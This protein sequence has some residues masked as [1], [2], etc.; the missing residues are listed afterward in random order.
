MLPVHTNQIK[1]LLVVVGFF[2]FTLQGFSQ[3]NEGTDFWFGFMEHRDVNDNT[4]VAMITS[5]FNTNGQISVPSQNWNQNFNI[6]ANQV[7]IITLPNFTENIGSETIDNLGIHLTSNT[8]TSVYI[9]Q[10][11]NF[12]SEATTVLPTNSLGKTYYVMSYRGV[13]HNGST[14]PSEFL[15]VGTEDETTFSI[16]VSDLTKGGQAAGNTFDIV[17]NQGETYQVQAADAAGDLTGSLIQADKN[18]TLLSGNSWTEI[19]NGCY[20]RD[21]LLEQMFPLE[22]WGKQIVTIPNAEMNYDVF[23]IMAAEDNTIVEVAGAT[24]TQ[25]YFINAGEFVEY[26][27][28]EPTYI[29][30]NQPIQ[31]AQ[32]NVGEACGGHTYGDPSMVLLNSVE[33]TRDTVTL[34]NSALQD[35]QENYINIIAAT[36][37]IPFI[38]FDGAPIPATASTGTVGPNDEFSF[39][40]LQVSSGAHTIISEACGIIATAYGYG[41]AESYAYSGGASFNS[42]NANPIPE[43]GCL[44]DTIYFDAKLPETRYSFF[45]DL[46]DGNTTTE[47]VFEHFYPSLGSYPVQLIITDECIGTVDTLNRDLV[48]SLRQ[49]VETIG[50][51]VTCE[52]GS[53]GL[54]ATDLAGATYEWIGPNGFFSEEQFPQVFNA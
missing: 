22:T 24:N 25:T 3:T 44:N 21:N 48:I 14:Y 1:L 15:I 34:Y 52:G 20:A 42:I 51:A 49:A 30:A 46:G 16:T 45:W 23:R 9:H 2:Q 39:I 29:Q 43:G 40:Q 4:K 50:D 28:S 5:K 36:T 41:S 32:F 26:Q 12:R 33:Q 7:T 38:T 17:L 53:F 13:Q 11:Q 37:D 31:V 35:I 27:K 8:P 18:F 47:S 6:T 19:P 54:G 10:Y